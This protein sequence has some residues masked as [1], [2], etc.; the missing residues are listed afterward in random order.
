[1]AGQSGTATIVVTVTDGLSTTVQR[2]GVTVW[3]MTGPLAYLALGE[4]GLAIV[5]LTRPAQPRQIAALDT[6]G[7]ASDIVVSRHVCLR[8]R[9]AEWVGGSQCG[10]PG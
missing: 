2:F 10:R 3:T 8:G 7:F 9:R 6:P 4:N 5:D 1:M